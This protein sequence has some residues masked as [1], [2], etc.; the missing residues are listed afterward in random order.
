MFE[1]NALFNAK[2]LSPAKAGRQRLIEVYG[3]NPLV[4]KTMATSI[5]E[6]FDGDVDAFLQEETLIFNGLRRLLDPE[7]ARLTTAEK[8]VMY[9]LA[10][11]QS[12]VT[13][14]KLQSLIQPSMSRPRLLETL[15]S[16]LRRSLIEQSVARFT[17]YPLVME[18]MLEQAIKQSE[19]F[20]CQHLGCEAEPTILMNLYTGI[21]QINFLRSQFIALIAAYQKMLAVARR[22][23][24]AHQEADALYNIAYGLYW[25][26]E[27]EPANDYAQQAYT[28][29]VATECKTVVAA[30]QFL[31]GYIHAVTAK[32]EDSIR[33]VTEALQLSQDSHD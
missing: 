22:C 8:Q 1:S 3:G 33:C 16:L 21:G 17:Q 32:L 28:L 25:R 10:I 29:A 27:F 12:S 7:F 13:I 24:N 9:W 19:E 6:L 2:G 18:Y 11:Q 31:M 14:S 15:E 26:H 20:L 30:S 4:L 5:R 23:E